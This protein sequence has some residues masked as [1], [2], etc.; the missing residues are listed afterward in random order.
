MESESY[1]RPNRSEDWPKGVTI[2]ILPPPAES[3]W[4]YTSA[5]VHSSPCPICE[6]VKMQKEAKEKVDWKTEG[7]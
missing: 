7:F 1:F 4:R 6:W 3:Q 5:T 2:R